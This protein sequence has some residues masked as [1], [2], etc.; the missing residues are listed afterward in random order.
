[1]LKTAL[2]HA[3]KLELIPTKPAKLVDPPKVK[4][5]RRDE[6]TVDHVRRLLA[7][8]ADNQRLESLLR[9]A[10]HMPLRPGELFGIE[11]DAL[12]LDQGLFDVRAN[13]V[14]LDREY[15][16]HDTKPHDRRTVP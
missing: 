9:L 16:L 15:L 3:W 13:L 7:A 5:A 14:R 8:T 11:W 1:M 12:D 2:Q 4:R 10:C 6:I